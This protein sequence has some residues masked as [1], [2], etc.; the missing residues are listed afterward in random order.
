MSKGK[1]IISLKDSDFYRYL[2]ENLQA[3]VTTRMT[4]SRIELIACKWEIGKEIIGS[5][6]NFEKFGYGENVIEI[7]S[8]DLNMSASDLY[9]CIQFFKKYPANDFDDIMMSLPEGNNLS[10]WLLSQK[11]L[12]DT[13]KK[14]QEENTHYISC[15]VDENGK[16]IYIKE[17]YDKYEIRYC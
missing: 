1:D 5:K 14:G 17:K 8:K 3:I 12:S 10:W 9:K 15:K 13:T 7:L 6:E 16:V 11:Y 2:I 4:N